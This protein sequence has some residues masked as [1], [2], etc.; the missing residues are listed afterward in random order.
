M[1]VLFCLEILGSETLQPTKRDEAVAWY[2]WTINNKYYTA[3][4][5]LCS[6]PNTY[7]VSS[8][9]AQSMQAFIAYFD[10]TVVCNLSAMCPFCGLMCVLTLCCNCHLQKDGLEKLKLWIPVVEDIAPEVLILV[11]DRTDENGW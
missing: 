5:R 8:E 10:S 7:S 6:V 11:C 1:C 4:V 2:F 3:D 9:I